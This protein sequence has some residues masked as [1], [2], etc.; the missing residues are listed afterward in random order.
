MDFVKVPRQSRA[1]E[2]GTENNHISAEAGLVDNEAIATASND[3]AKSP[4]ITTHFDLERVGL[5]A[6]SDAIYTA[7]ELDTELYTKLFGKIQLVVEPLS[8]VRCTPHT[9]LSY[10][11]AK[12]PLTSVGD[13]WCLEAE[14]ARF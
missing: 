2:S 11:R 8:V 5:C 9:S 3:P 6:T 10:H 1:L 7:G 12:T 4:L 14:F 13:I